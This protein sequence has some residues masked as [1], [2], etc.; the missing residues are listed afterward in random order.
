MHSTY[1]D[2][3]ASV[4][5]MV[6]SSVDK[7]LNVISITD[8]DTF[9]GSKAAARFIKDKGIDIILIYG[10]EVRAKYYG[11]LMDILILCPSLPPSPPPKD[12]L[13]LYDW[14]EKWG[15]LYVP[16]HPYDERRYGC[17]ETIY[18][19]EMHAIEAWNA[20]ASRKTNERAVEVARILK[21]PMLANSD[22]HDTSMIAS[23]H[24]IIDAEPTVDDTLEAILKGKTKIVKGHVSPKSY[25]RYIGKKLARK[26]VRHLFPREYL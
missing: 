12:E 26:S 19:L 6:V 22:A 3:M 23:A 9:E 21:K 11:K 18:D 15:C 4:E 8:H 20:R 2:G 10:N 5:K 24:T 14:A 7:G 1:S 16:A 17:G 25:A 13:R